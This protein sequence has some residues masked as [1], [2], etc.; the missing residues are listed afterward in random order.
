M[1]E[2]EKRPAILVVDDEEGL[3]ETVQRMLSVAYRVVGAADA[4]SAITL[5]KAEPPDLVLTDIYMPRG[6]G[7]E[8]LNWM[9]DNVPDIPAV[10]MSGS[11][12]TVGGNTRFDQLS[13]AQRLG[14]AAVLDK[15][16]RQSHL[17]ETI[18]RVL[19]K[20]EPQAR[21]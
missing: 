3:R 20:G 16:F 2:N 19:S 12:P 6:D 21:D 11:S 15:P 4:V 9:R 18:E 10:A 1:S 13:I 5:I 14:A 17:L 7:F 8:L